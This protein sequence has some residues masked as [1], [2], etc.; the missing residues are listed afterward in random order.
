MGFEDQKQARSASS[1]LS[2]MSQ[3]HAETAST[4]ITTGFLMASHLSA[5]DWGFRRF[6][7]R[8]SAECQALQGLWGQA[9]K[10]QLLQA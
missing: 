6:I 1:L 10:D 2:E 7:D 8:N 5:S 3:G 9:G 4:W